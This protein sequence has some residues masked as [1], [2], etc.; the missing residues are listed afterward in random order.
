[1]KC[2][3]RTGKWNLS[4]LWSFY[5]LAASE[6]ETEYSLVNSAKPSYLNTER[7]LEIGPVVLEFTRNIPIDAQA[8]IQGYDYVWNRIRPVKTVE[9][10]TLKF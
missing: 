4:A 10:R 3:G 8:S 7:I 9:A 5:G 2:F 1:M 6:S